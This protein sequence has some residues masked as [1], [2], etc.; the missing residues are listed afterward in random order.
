MINFTGSNTAETLGAVAKCDEKT[1]NNQLV[2][3]RVAFYKAIVD[4]NKTQEKFL[5]GW[6]IRAEKFRIK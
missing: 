6:L 3:L 5:K 4:R 2:D 1:L